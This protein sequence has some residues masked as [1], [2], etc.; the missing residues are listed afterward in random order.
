MEQLAP[1]LPTEAQHS[2]EVKARHLAIHLRTEEIERL[3]QDTEARTEEPRRVRQRIKEAAQQ[4]LA[5]LTEIEVKSLSSELI[6]RIEEAVREGHG[7]RA[8]SIIKDFLSQ[9]HEIPASDA[10]TILQNSEYPR[11]E[12]LSVPPSSAP[13]ED[14][15]EADLKNFTPRDRLTARD[16][17]LPSQSHAM[18]VFLRDHCLAAIKRNSVAAAIDHALD[19]LLLAGNGQIGTQPWSEAGLAILASLPAGSLEATNWGQSLAESL[20]DS[21][22]SQD[23]STLRNYLGNLILQPDFEEAISERFVHSE[24]V[25]FVDTLAVALHA[26]VSVHR[27]YLL[28]DVARAIGACH[29]SAHPA[30]MTASIASSSW[31]AWTTKNCS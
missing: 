6:D 4:L 17:Q 27:P 29:Y 10:P 16:P 1:Y 24:L 15:F 13:A 23:S 30:S 5:F 28:E 31:R 22:G 26:S 11:S 7:D 18:I 21:L 20:R 25:P 8:T 2:L 14:R 3:L 12:S 9:N 19:I